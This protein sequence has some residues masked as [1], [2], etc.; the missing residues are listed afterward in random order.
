MRLARG[1]DTCRKLMGKA[2][3]SMLLVKH[4]AVSLGYN[5]SQCSGKN[6]KPLLLLFMRAK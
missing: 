1:N 4:I 2:L 3:R 6:P 5:I